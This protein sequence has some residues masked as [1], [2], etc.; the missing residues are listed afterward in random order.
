MMG[1]TGFAW[2]RSIAE[3]NRAVE[4]A[5]AASEPAPQSVAVLPLV[6][7][8]PGG[9]NEYLGDG[10]A[11]EI[12]AQL[13][14]IPGL[15]VAARTSAF[16]FKDKSLDV[17]KIGQALGVHHVLEG[18]V[19]RDGDKLRVT[20]QLIDAANGYH[21]WA[22]SYDKD[23]SDVISIQDNISQS[24]ARAR[25]RADAGIG[26]QAETQRRGE[27]CRL[28]GVSVWCIRAAQVG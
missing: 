25:S 16:E 15:R 14:Q 26:A 8:T 18:S 21:V 17:R 7:M 2:W 13:A 27:P 19:R 20:V 6:D 5:P 12:S 28:R 24:I 4:P 10:F 11:E 9:G 1:V 22:G 23:W 3:A